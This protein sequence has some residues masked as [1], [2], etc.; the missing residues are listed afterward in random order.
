MVIGG[1]GA[2][3]GTTD[4]GG[5]AGYGTV[6]E[7][8]PPSA[9]GGAWTSAVL[10]SFTGR[11]GGGSV[12]YGSPL[13]SRSGEIYGTTYT[14][15]A[16]SKGTVYELTPPAG[17]GPWM[18]VILY[19]FTGL[20]GDGTGPFAGVVFGKNGV[21]YGTTYGGGAASSKGGTI[22]GLAPPVSG[23]GPWTETVVYSFAGPLN[24]YGSGPM[25]GLAVGA[26]GQLFGVTQY[27]GAASSGTAFELT[28]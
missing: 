13:L 26:N 16:A 9:P 23:S 4:Y 12:A 24:G 15:G 27:G 6:Y 8:T 20:H 14:G 2:L 11:N 25:A 18:I 17:S 3:F 19:S 7:L 5:T 21:L 10:Y 22:Y 28:F 1:G